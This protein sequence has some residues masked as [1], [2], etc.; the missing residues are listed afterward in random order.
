MLTSWKTTVP[1]ILALLAVVWNAWQ[2]K[3]INI[4]DVIAALVGVG[5]VQAKDWNV[6]GGNKSL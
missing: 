3:T 6:T 2:T 1:G 4:D 5:L